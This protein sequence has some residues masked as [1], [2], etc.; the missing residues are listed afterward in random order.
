MPQREWVKRTDTST[1]IDDVFEAEVVMKKTGMY[2]LDDSGIER[3]LE[4]SVDEDIWVYEVDGS[5]L[6]AALSE[7]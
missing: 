5:N 6:V 2:L 7:E 1:G 4:W 3:M